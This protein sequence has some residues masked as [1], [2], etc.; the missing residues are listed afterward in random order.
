M[1]K[2]QQI[3]FL[4]F[5]F[6][7]TIVNAQ[8]KKWTLQECVDHALQHNTTILQQRL[9][10]QSTEK[11]TL[12]AKGNFYPSLSASASQNFNFGSYIDNYGGRVSRNSSS[13]SFGIN[14]GVTLYNGGRNVN[15]LKLAEKRVENAH[16]SVEET[17]NSTLLYIV[18]LYL[19][20][21][22]NKEAV[23][24]ANEQIEISKKQVERSKQL[25]ENGV[26]PKSV[27]LESEAT[28]ASSYEKL[29]N[30][31]NNLA[32]SKLNLSQALQI[33][34][35]NFDIEEVA[36]SIDKS[37]LVYKN[38]DDVYNK[39]AASF[40]EIKKAEIAIENAELSSK[41]AKAGYYPVL[42]LG[43]GVGTSYQHLLGEKD[44]RTVL[45]SDGKPITISNGFQKQMKDNLGYNVGLSL[46]IPIFDRFQN[47]VNVAR[48]K[49]SQEQAKIQLID[50]QLKL[51][52]NVE[53]AY[54]EAKAALN[55]FTAAEKS[56]KAQEESYKNAEESYNAGIMT[57]FDF[58]QVRNR[59]VN[60]KS[61][62]INAKYN[63]IFKTK[64]VEYY[65]GMPIEIK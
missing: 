13:N 31:Q 19:G 50:Q 59:L 26:K 45:N 62:M 57:S 37:S 33:S 36:V 3:T 12:I 2:K 61:S 55:Q 23:S 35:Q 43:G 21:L 30:A 54:I 10:A 48:A 27:L 64:V 32:L 9:N 53:S 47:K 17:K 40:P 56:L 29:A 60:A 49:I 5:T 63:Y 58:E 6:L 14:T 7:I 38:V 41:I 44:T 18:N 51:R 15:N 16:L 24:I 34:A 8:E 52:K 25:V 65:Y 20:I 22:L 39:A 11:E 1:M 46:N 4:L 28:L 42:S